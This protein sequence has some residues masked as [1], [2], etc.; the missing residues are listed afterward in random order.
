MTHVRMGIYA[1]TSGTAEEV[2]QTAEEGMLS[3]FRSQPGFEGYG[4]AKTGDDQL[5]SV[6]LWASREQAQQASE[7]AKSWV[8]ENI[9]D[10][11]R[12]DS[13]YVGDFLFFERAGEA[14]EVQ[15]HMR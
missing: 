7:L 5:V 6:S 1:V 12:L 13:N 3:V 10:R 9:A 4:L 11:V 14:A 8:A 15:A 2:G